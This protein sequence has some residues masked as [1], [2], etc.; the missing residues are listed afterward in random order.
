MRQVFK[1]YY[2]S[3]VFV[4]IYHGISNIE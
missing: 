1:F 2:E 4:Y 3:S